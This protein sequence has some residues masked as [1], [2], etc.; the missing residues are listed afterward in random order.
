MW[1]KIRE[2]I[3]YLTRI[4]SG[5]SS[6]N[7]RSDD[8]TRCIISVV[9]SAFSVGLNLNFHLL[10]YWRDIATCSFNFIAVKLINYLVNKLQTFSGC[11]PANDSSFVVGELIDIANV[12]QTNRWNRSRILDRR[13][14]R[15]NGDVVILKFFFNLSDLM[16]EIRQINDGIKWRGFTR[17]R[18]LKLLWRVTRRTLTWEDHGSTGLIVCVWM[19]TDMSA[20][21]LDVIL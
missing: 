7:H 1:F 15:Q 3:S 12:W 14:Q 4:F 5:I 6:T 17:L 8:S 21:S 2:K 9:S 19:T 11:A 16:P 10:E 18:E 20:T 13:R